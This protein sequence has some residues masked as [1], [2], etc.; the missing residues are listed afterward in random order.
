M[1]DVKSGKALTAAYSELYPFTT[2]VL[3]PQTYTFAITASITSGDSV[4]T[5]FT[6]TLND[7]C[8][9]S[10]FFTLKSPE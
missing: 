5:T 7:P 2:T 8:T 1:E 9:E 3:P 10:G 6:W 4:S